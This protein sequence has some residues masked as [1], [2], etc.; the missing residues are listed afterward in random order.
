MLSTRARANVCAPASCSVASY[1]VRPQLPLARPEPL[2]LAMR[3]PHRRLITLSPSCPLHLAPSI[4]A[5]AILKILRQLPLLIQ[6]STPERTL[7][8]VYY[9]F[10]LSRLL[11]FSAS[12]P[13]VRS[14]PSFLSDFSAPQYC[15]IA[16]NSTHHTSP[17]KIGPH[18]ETCT[19]ASSSINAQHT[20]TR[21]HPPPR[22]A[23]LVQPCSEEAFLAPP[24]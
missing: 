7:T 8:F 12:S 13:V 24:W 16:F 19:R 14:V 18:C 15:K 6:L 1:T 17:I 10:L 9:S 4:K 20:H 21:T 23:S 11:L 5:C 2:T 3:P 22:S